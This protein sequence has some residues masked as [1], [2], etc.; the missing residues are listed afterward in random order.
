MSLRYDRSFSSPWLCASVPVLSGVGEESSS[1]NG[2]V[3]NDEEFLI[4]RRHFIS[5]DP[6]IFVLRA[7][8]ATASPESIASVD[9]RDD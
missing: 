9:M 3:Q 8:K 5:V 2:I 1:T 4:E 7:V 6:R